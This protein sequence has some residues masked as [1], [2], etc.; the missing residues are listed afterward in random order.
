MNVLWIESSVGE[1]KTVRASDKLFIE[2]KDTFR[3]MQ[4]V[5]LKLWGSQSSAVL[6]ECGIKFKHQLMQV[7]L[8]LSAA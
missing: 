5:R 8:V 7:N 2:R 1:R 4:K 3:N 6:A